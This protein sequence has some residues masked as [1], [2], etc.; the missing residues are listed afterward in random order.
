MEVFVKQ[1]EVFKRM[2]RNKRRHG[3]KDVIAGRA[4]PLK[5]TRTANGWHKI[6]FIPKYPDDAANALLDDE[7]LETQQGLEIHG[8]D[9]RFIFKTKDDV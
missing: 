7:L 6:K 4:E 8:T 2:E 9:D 3:S 5:R 1:L